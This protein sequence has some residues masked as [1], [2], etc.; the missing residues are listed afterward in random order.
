MQEQTE[1]IT[2]SKKEVCRLEIIQQLS[3]RTI[4]QIEA[5]KQ[6]KLST[7]QV[8][9]IHK[10]Y[11]RLGA[12]ALV[13]KKRNR[14]SNNQ[15]GPNK[16]KRALE[17][18][19]TDYEGFGPTLAQ[20]KLYEK[21]QLKFSIETVRKIMITHGL[22]K[23]K[24]RKKVK[25]HQM[26]PRRSCFGELVQIDGSPHDWFEGRS[27]RCCLIVFIDDATGRLLH[28]SF[29]P[30]EST[31][32]YFDATE[33]YIQRYGRPIAFYSDKHSI[34]RI[35]LPEA[36]QSSGETQFGR[37]LRELGIGLICANSPQAKGRVERANK[38]LQDRLIKEMRLEK[39]NTIE[40]ANEYLP[41]FIKQYNLKFAVSAASD[42]DA[43]K[44]SFPEQ[45]I[46]QLIF[47]HQ[48]TRTI[49][50]NL[51]VR[52]NNALYQIQAHTK[53]YA[54]RN[55]KVTV[56]DRK[57]DIKLIYKGSLLAYKTFD[58]HNR[59]APIIDTK[60]INK[61][62]EQKANHKPKSDHPWRQYKTKNN[63]SIAA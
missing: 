33:L 37:A 8:R 16:I 29:V 42:I 12:N 6:L 9:R 10:D 40:Q 63:Q 3:C 53:S 13:S 4:T 56:S 17:L 1:V 24:G 39:I 44:K 28:L 60:Q 19:R 36:E 52:Y 18:L 45:D 41:K 5:A 20:E 34:F 14:P 58:K 43:H 61:Y 11:M 57:G 48:S 2:M 15:V 50:K 62:V 25:H 31:Q 55:A 49:S 54:M 51:E 30:E 7:R 38:T 59:P 35:N 47:S 27:E 26:R 23:P 46:M 32:A 21:H 22:W